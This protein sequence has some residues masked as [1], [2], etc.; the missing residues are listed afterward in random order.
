[1]QIFSLRKVH[2]NSSCNE[3]DRK[4]ETFSVCVNV[5]RGTSFPLRAVKL[6][7]LVRYRRTGPAYISCTCNYATHITAK[8]T[9]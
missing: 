7:I 9:K 1:M 3:T 6:Q 4:V 5:E 2:S 8:E